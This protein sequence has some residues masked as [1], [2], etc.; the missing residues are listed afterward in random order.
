MEDEKLEY[1]AEFL[2][3]GT[4]VYV[5]KVHRF[6]TDAMLLSHFCNLRRNEDGCDLGTGC[7]IIPLR[8][9]DN[10]HRGRAVG[11]EIDGEG[12]RLLKLAAETNNAPNILPICADLREYKSEKLFDVV[13][14]NPPYFTGGFMSEKPGRA[15]HRHQISCTTKDVCAAAARLLKDKGRFCVCQRPESLADVM[16]QMV[17]CGIQPKRLRFVKQSKDDTPWLFLLDGRKAGG[18]GLSIMPDLIMGN[19]MGGYSDEVLRIYGKIK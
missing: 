9:F 6:G 17:M 4:R 1:N 14:C 15:Q 5:S 3:G 13:T 12:T 18:V 16:A 19:G 10:G 8:W 7:G 2:S 11:V